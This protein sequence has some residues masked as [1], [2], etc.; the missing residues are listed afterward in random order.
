MPATTN[1]KKLL[2]PT[3]M[4][5]AGWAVIEAREDVEGVAYSVTGPKQ[6]LHR[7]LADAA[8]VALSVQPFS[9][10][11]LDAGPHLE[12][13]ARIGVGYDAVD[14]PALTRRKL[15]LMIAG[16][17]NSVSVAEAGVYL[18]MNLA[19]RGAAMDRM[20]KEGRWQ[21][22]YKEM[23]VDLYG[24]TA[25]IIGF[26]K[27]GTR[28]AKRLAAMEMNVLVYDPYMYSETIRG[29]GYEPVG[30]LDSAV[31]R[32]DFITIHCP[33]TA[34]TVGLFNAA[35][36][37]RMKPTAF[38][39]NTARGG[40]IDEKALYDVLKA[41]RIAGAALDVFAEEPTPQ[42]NP[43]LTLPNF[44]A[45]PHMAGVTKEAV[46]RMAIVTAQN[47]LSVLDGTPNRENVVNKEVL[48]SPRRS[49]TRRGSDKARLAGPSSAMTDTDDVMTAQ[50]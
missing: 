15:P 36:L 6:E 34:E 11:E 41:N 26:G 38:I 24:K 43:L 48:S 47:L 32:A 27:I 20:V 1:I 3:T 37:A 44:V 9:D 22:R 8:G 40:I 49:V 25:L 50:I 30:D 18:L 35:R 45:A 21:D 7:L 42:D 12:V 31:A 17:A 14:V 2:L 29:M 39:V 33:K 5:K 46:D 13:V 19:R 23:P 16:T 28:S 4:A 10:P